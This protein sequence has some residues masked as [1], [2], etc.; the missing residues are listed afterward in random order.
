MACGTSSRGR[1]WANK[2]KVVI[3]A[4]NFWEAPLLSPPFEFLTS[5][6]R[7]KTKDQYCCGGMRLLTKISPSYQSWDHEQ[8]KLLLAAECVH[9]DS[10]QSADRR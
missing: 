7:S 1:I 6:N 8:E 5:R 9:Q 3:H 10:R 2:Y 4:T